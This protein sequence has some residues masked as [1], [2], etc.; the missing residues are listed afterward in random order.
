[1]VNAIRLSHRDFVGVGRIGRDVPLRGWIRTLTSMVKA[2]LE[3][4]RTIDANLY[5]CKCRHETSV[6][7]KGFLRSYF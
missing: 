1:M 7:T 3:K 4:A 2:D 6:F 5:K